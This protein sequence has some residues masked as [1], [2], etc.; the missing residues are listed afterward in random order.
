MIRCVMRY[1]CIVKMSSIGAGKARLEWIGWLM[2]GCVVRYYLCN[3]KTSLIEADR[4]R[5]YF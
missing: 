5:L 3:G 4:A 1:L 2:I